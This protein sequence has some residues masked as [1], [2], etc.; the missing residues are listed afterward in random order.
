MHNEDLILVYPN[1]GGYNFMPGVRRGYIPGHRSGNRGE[2]NGIAAS[3]Y[4]A[5]TE[6]ADWDVHWVGENYI[7]ARG[8]WHNFSVPDLQAGILANT[9]FPGQLLPSDI[10]VTLKKY[11][12]EM[13]TTDR[14][15]KLQPYDTDILPTADTIAPMTDDAEMLLA[16]NAAAPA[17]AIDLP[18]HDTV[19]DPV[20]DIADVPAVDIPAVDAA[21][22]PVVDTVDVIHTVGV[23]V[24]DAADVSVVA[25][26]VVGDDAVDVTLPNDDTITLSVDDA[27]ASNSNHVA[28]TAPDTFT[29]MLMNV[30]T[31][32][33][34]PTAIADTSSAVNAIGPSGLDRLQP[35]APNASL[36]SIQSAAVTRLDISTGENDG[37]EDAE[38]SIDDG[39]DGEILRLPMTSRALYVAENGA[40]KD[41]EMTDVQSV[42]D[43]TGDDVDTNMLI[44]GTFLSVTV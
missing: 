25:V 26:N 20:D 6:Y 24:V 16:D 15:F 1:L 3:C 38:G 41:V 37:S 44:D 29:R 33:T 43:P 27:T 10:N 39:E 12:D 23:T 5:L 7:D 14:L 40:E 9:P 11:Y 31:A 34:A 36:A 42:L 8:R 18:T 13:A 19:D 28:L 35:D 4:N 2:T 30:A 17:A 32:P 22:A 21:D